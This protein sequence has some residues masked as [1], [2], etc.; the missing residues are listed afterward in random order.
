VLGHHAT[1]FLV[2]RGGFSWPIIQAKNRLISERLAFVRRFPP[3][4]TVV[5]AS[6]A[7]NAAEYYLPDYRVVDVFYSPGEQVFGPHRPT[8]ERART[9]ILFDT[10]LLEANRSPESLQSEALPI[11]LPI[12]YFQLSPDQQVVR[13]KGGYR[14]ALTNR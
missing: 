10:Q 12:F 13:W 5:F 7:A 6:E 11:G 2:A 4:E 8:A 9:I 3:N 1:A 14:L